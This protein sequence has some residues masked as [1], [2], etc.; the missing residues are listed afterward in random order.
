MIRSNFVLS[1]NILILGIKI[2]NFYNAYYKNIIDFYYLN[3]K[4]YLIIKIR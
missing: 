2:Y 3:K 4:S 1:Y